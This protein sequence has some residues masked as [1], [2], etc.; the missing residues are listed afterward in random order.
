VPTIAERLR[1]PRRV[2]Q[3]VEHLV[4]QHLRPMHLAQAGQITRRARFRFFRALGDDAPDLLLL[5][6][7]DAAALTGASPLA[8]WEGEG[9]AV[10][11][12]LM[13]GAEEEATAGRVP[14]LLRGE[15][16]MD[17]FGLSPGP[18]VGRLLERAREA[19]SLG[20]VRS[21][22]EA[23]AHL[24]ESREEGAPPVGT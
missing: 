15:D 13:A 14:P 8:V 10:V 7:A 18:A 22:E 21:R 24:R 4:A 12:A 6:L 11:R 5:S 17:A 2:G 23:L 19:Q 9:G 1:L 16:V 20:L 3:V